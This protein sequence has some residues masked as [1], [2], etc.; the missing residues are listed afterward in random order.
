MKLKFSM[1]VL[2]LTLSLAGTGAWAQAPA[3][4]ASAPASVPVAGSGPIEVAPG[5]PDKHV[6]VKGDTLWD[7][8]GKFLVKPWRWPEIWQLNRE[9]IRNPHLIYPGDI[10]YLDT[11]GTTPRLRLGKPLAES[12]VLAS[13][14]T[15]GTADAGERLERAQPRVRARVVA[16]EA[17]PTIRAGA[18]E[19]FLNRPLIVDEKG[20]QD[21]PRIVGTQEGRVYLGRGDLAYVRGLKDQTGTDW[22]VYRSA[23]PLLDPG[24]RLPIAHEAIF[25]GTARLERQGDPA[26]FRIISADEEIGTGDRLVAAE[27][28]QSLN[29][30]PRPPEAKMA[31]RI[32]S[33]YRGVAQ[34][35]RNSVVSVNLGS[36]QGLAVGN[37]LAI[38]E[39][40]RQIKDPET[41]EIIS[42]AGEPIGLLLVFRVFDKIAYGLI[43]DAYKAVTVGDDIV[44]P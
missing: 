17:I 30:A 18:I 3:N 22:F 25:L 39:R 2:A 44:N 11:S 13:A 41:K 29:V 28:T 36:Q 14:Y 16:E 38:K 19:P 32:V 27:R 21:H 35:G 40:P 43:V 31:G 10:V 12:P 1:R 8:A 5:A 33:V 42:L 6:V 9:Q 15:A 7:I 37:V 34:A 4:P 24:T 26:V 23:R 20:L